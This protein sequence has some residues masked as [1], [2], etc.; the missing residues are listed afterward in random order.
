VEVV[1]RLSVLLVVAVLSLVSSA[2]ADDL[3]DEADLEFQLGAEAYT[4]GEYRPALEHFLRSNRLVHN[5]NVV[6]NIA[7]CYEQLGQYPSAWRSYRRALE[8][9]GDEAFRKKVDEALA[10]ITP[11]VSIIEVKSSPP[12]ATVYIDRKDLGSRGETPLALALAPGKYT[13]LLEKGS[14]EAGQP[15]AVELAAG[16]TRVVELTLAPILGQVRIQGTPRASV[17]IDRPDG[18]ALGE[19]PLTLALPVG[20]HRIYAALAGKRT[21]EIDVDVQARA[22]VTVAAQLEATFG[23]LVVSSDLRDALIQVDER[24]V[25]FSP[26]VVQVPVGP[27]RVRISL[28]GFKAIERE[29]HIEEGKQTRWAIRPSPKPSGAC[30]VSI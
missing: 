15:Q 3:A 17:R 5:R 9:A 23:S 26:A 7:R 30:A 12:G 11:H 22:T 28:A 16:Q 13:L 24:P 14:H 29:V 2:R 20:R 1:H 21:K 10:R 4:R 19:V 18:P 27:H 6:F 25:G 8:Q